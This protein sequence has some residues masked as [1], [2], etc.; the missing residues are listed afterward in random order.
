MV[1]TRRTVLRSGIGGLALAGTETAGLARPAASLTPARTADDMSWTGW[2]PAAPGLVTSSALACLA[3]PVAGAAVWLFGTGPDNRIYANRMD[4]NGIWAGWREVPGGALTDT[5]VSA[6]AGPRGGIVLAAKGPDQAV[7][8]NSTSDGSNWT[9]WSSIGGET[10]VSPLMASWMHVY[11]AGPDEEIFLH[12]FTGWTLV[13]GN[14]LTTSAMCLN[15]FNLPG[16]GSA[17]VLFAIGTDNRVYGNPVGVTRGVST[18][19][20]GIWTEVAGGGRTDAGPAIAPFADHTA[21]LLL[22]KGVADQRIF[23]N[24]TDGFPDFGGWAE[25]PGHGRTNLAPC[26]ATASDATGHERIFVFTVGT[27]GTPYLNIGS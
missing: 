5:A 12:S 20:T 19:I 11:T 8:V 17:N 13:P 27:D 2:A 16:G 25:L 7:R 18:P 9:G 15:R 10:N 22:V 14:A 4:G 26:A 6:G 21:A 23:L 3:S 1:P 24:R